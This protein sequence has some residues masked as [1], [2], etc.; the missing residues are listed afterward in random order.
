MSELTIDFSERE[1]P[2]T[3]HEKK[4]NAILSLKDDVAYDTYY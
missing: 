4:L 1:N 2:L 3:E